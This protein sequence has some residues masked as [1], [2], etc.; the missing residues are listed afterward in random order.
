MGFGKLFLCT[1]LI[2]HWASGHAY[3]RARVGLRVI[4]VALMSLSWS[5][6]FL[7][8]KPIVQDG[9]SYLAAHT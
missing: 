6:F 2:A 8:G 5:D 3:T 9:L 4:F 7:G 1:F